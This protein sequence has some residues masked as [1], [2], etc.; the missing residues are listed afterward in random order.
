LGTPI[1]VA[2]EVHHVYDVS[3]RSE[4]ETQ[5]RIQVKRP[6]TATA[7]AASDDADMTVEQIVA[8][9]RWLD[10]MLTDLHG[11]LATAANPDDLRSSA[12]L[13]IH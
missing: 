9:I 10:A 3:I 4:R 2:Y 12:I 13:R 1:V 7:I 5:R 6:F 8:R 11:E